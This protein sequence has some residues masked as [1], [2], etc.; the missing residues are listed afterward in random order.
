[1]PALVKLK[2]ERCLALGADQ[3]QAH[4]VLWYAEICAINDM[5][6]DHVAQRCH[7]LRPGRVQGPVRKFF[8]V[9]D[10]HHF[11]PVELGS[12]HNRPGC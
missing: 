2:I 11:R 7:C 6:R 5:R 8:D 9:L 4:A 3:K 12:R 1:M 10:Q